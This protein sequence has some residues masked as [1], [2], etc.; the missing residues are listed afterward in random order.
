MEE[1]YKKAGVD[2]EAGYQLVKEIQNLVK[3][4]HNPNVLSSIG[5]FGGLFE[6]PLGAYT[7][8]VLVS[9][10][11]GVGT[12]L[13]VAFMTNIHHTIGSDLVNHCINDI[14][15][16]GA[17]PLF[18]MD[19]IGTSGLSPGIISGIIKGIVNSCRTYGCALLGGETAEMPGFYQ[20]KE[21]DVAGTIVGIVD[22]D[23][24]ITGKTISAGDIVIGLPSSGLHTNGYSLARHI[25]FDQLQWKPDHHLPQCG[26]TLGEELL[27][28]HR[29]YLNEIKPWLGTSLIK[30]MAHITGGGFRGNINRIL[31]PEVD[32]L[33]DTKLWEPLPIFQTLMEKGKVNRTEM[34]DVFNMGIGMTV[35]IAPQDETDLVAS[36]PESGRIGRI[37]PGT[38][39]VHLE[40]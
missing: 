34:Y 18:F 17:V 4:I 32:A 3:E 25:F 40:F 12:K 21:Y 20:N 35:V 14:L 39:K 5:G 23:R 11:D 24:I 29:C 1:L 15:V 16:Q 9:S 6:V 2:T 13:K 33:I 10:I 7:R 28:I 22:Y 8:P 19:Y 36:F 31:P 38:G 30:G 37:I 27:K 26:C